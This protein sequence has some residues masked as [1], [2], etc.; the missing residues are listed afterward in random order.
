MDYK[1]TP[2]WQWLAL[3]AI[4]FAQALG[5][6]L[7]KPTSYRIYIWWGIAAGVIALAGAL[8]NWLERRAAGKKPTIQI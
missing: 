1:P 6:Y 5:A 2:M 7:R 3:A 4:M 8:F